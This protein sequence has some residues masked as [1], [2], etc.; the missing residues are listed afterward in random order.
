LKDNILII[1][2]GHAGSMAAILLRQKKYKGSISIVSE[3]NHLPYQRPPLSKAYLLGNTEKKSLYF[4]SREYYKNNNIEFISNKTAIKIDR[5]DS[6]VLLDDGEHLKYKSLIIATGS[7]LNRLKHSSKNQNIYYLK[8][9]EDSIKLRSVFKKHKKIVIIGAGYI[10]LEVASA[11]I[12]NKLDVTVIETTERVMNRSVCD[13]TSDF[14][15]NMHIKAGVKFLFN[16]SVID[17]KDI[18]LKKRIYLN[19]ESSLDADA[20]IIGIGISPNIK[21][22]QDSGLDCSNGIIVNEYCQTSHPKIYAIG[23][24]TEHPNKIYQRRVRLESVHNAAEQAKTASGVICGKKKPYQQ[25]P[26]FWTEQY[27]LK[28]QIAGLSN[29]YDDI[30]LRGNLKDK[31][32]SIFYLKNKKIIAVDAINDNQS[33]L[34]GRK[35]IKIE[36]NIS[37]SKLSDVKI[38]LRDL[39]KKPYIGN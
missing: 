26:W 3:E 6:R 10:G 11:L 15:M 27:G 16:T 29:D 14:I 24:C 17:I 23:D 33:F 12:K 8:T 9:I 22:A 5:A 20:I 19:N 37:K 36:A 32:F 1:G 30:V 35:L 31:K 34:S 28:I 13:Q 7:K 39:I 18:N 25:V 21:L 4:K 38:N 2:G